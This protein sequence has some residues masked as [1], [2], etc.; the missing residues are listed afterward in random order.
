M[1]K[2]WLRAASEFAVL[3]I[4]ELCVAGITI[5]QSGVSFIAGQKARIQFSA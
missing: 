4:P 3:N 5:R 2:G 1:S